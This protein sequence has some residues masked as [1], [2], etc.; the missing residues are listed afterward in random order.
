MEN[1]NFK[2]VMLTV[3]TLSVFTLAVVELMGISNWSFRSIATNGR[4]N[5]FIDKNGQRYHGI[6]YPEDMRSRYQ[7]VSQMP[8]TT[9][10]FYETKF[11]FGSV[12]EG[13]IVTHVFRYKNTGQNPLMISKTDVTCGC[14][15]SNFQLESVAPGNDGEMAVEFDT[16][17]K[18]G[19][20]QKNIT[21]H[22]NALPEAVTIG[23]EAD[24]K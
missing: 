16:K 21:V 3:F 4:D 5:N 17:G 9:I 20:Q 1:S 7:Q 2:V 8:K 11:N 6:I 18:F 19:I 13:N 14:T 15:V 22:S 10:Q 24:V 23:I 12:K